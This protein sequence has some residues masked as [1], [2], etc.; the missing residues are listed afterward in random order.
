MIKVTWLAHSCFLLENE[1]GARLL[2]D[3]YDEC[4]GYQ[5]PKIKA[6][7]VTTSHKHGDHANLDM[8]EGDS[9][10]YT[11][12]DT[13]G[14]FEELGF[15]VNGVA[16]KHDDEGGQKRGDIII[17][18]VECENVRICHL[19]DLGHRL[20]QSQ[21]DAIG[22]VDV[23]MIPVGGFYTIDAKTA[24]EVVDDLNPLVVMP[25]HYKTDSSTYPIESEQ[26]FLDLMQKAEYSII[27]HHS[28]V[29]E[30]SAEKLP[31]RHAVVVLDHMY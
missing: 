15:K 30:F 25:I 22:H 6:D 11:L 14:S 3:P 28:P 18:V 8:V 27:M 4:T 16:A 17:Y 21:I 7:L 31:R 19:G 24:K 26:A 9:S 29:R 10:N 12:I 20:N 23:L 1:T 5:V 2:M 13:V